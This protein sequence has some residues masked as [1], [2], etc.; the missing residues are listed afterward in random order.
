MNRLLLLDILI[1]APLL[2]GAAIT[3]LPL[4]AMAGWL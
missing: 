3:F 4:L 2:L 1:G